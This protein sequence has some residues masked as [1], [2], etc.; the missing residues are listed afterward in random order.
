MR[1]GDVDLVLA[2]LP[3]HVLEAPRPHS[4]DRLPREGVPGL[5]PPLRAVVR[6]GAELTRGSLLDDVLSASH[7]DDR[8]EQREGDQDDHGAA[9][10]EPP[11][12]LR[13]TTRCSPPC[14]PERSERAQEDEEPEP[15][16]ILHA[17]RVGLEI[18]GDARLGQPPDERGQ[19][20]QD[21]DA[22]RRDAL[23]ALARQGEVG[24]DREDGCQQPAA[25]VREHDRD[26]EHVHEDDGHGPQP[27]IV[28]APGRDPEPKG[29]TER[30]QEREA[31]SSSRPASGGAQSV[32][33]PRRA[34][35]SPSRPAPTGRRRRSARRG[36]VRPSWARV[37][38]RRRRPAR[39]RQRPDRRV[40]G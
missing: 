36:P 30:G 16:P 4:D 25:R 40:R 9:D 29:Q 17:H 12:P 14:D 8:A 5:A 10:D 18:V 35:G 6:A 1:L 22:E 31:R 21:G 3:V 11:G 33:S 7:G 23:H 24:D 13:D 15:G 26:S 19:S 27:A 28:L 34:R 39:A 38:R 32:R 20:R 2:E 37:E